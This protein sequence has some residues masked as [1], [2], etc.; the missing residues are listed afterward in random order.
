MNL[1]T[2]LNELKHIYG[3][4]PCC[5]EPFRLSE[6]TLFTKSRPPRTVFEQMQDDQDRLDRQIEKFDEREIDIRDE[7]RRLGQSEARR[8]LR[9]IAPFFVAKRIDPHDVKLLFHPVEYI[10]FRGMQADRCASVDFIDHP[11]TDRSREKIQR[12]LEQA[13]KAGNL[14]W[15]TL[16]IGED[17]RVLVDGRGVRTFSF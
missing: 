5:G 17:G 2:V 14:E 13:I 9:E 7:A 16:R 15:Q 3:I 11:A 1:V 12:S 10:V 8:K 4:C 6:A